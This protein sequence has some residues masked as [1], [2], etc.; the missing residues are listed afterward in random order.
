MPAVYVSCLQFDADSFTQVFCLVL[1]GLGL[2]SANPLALVPSVAA[3]PISDH[4]FAAA[5]RLFCLVQVGLV[6][7]RQRA[8]PRPRFAVACACFAL[9]AIAEAAAG[10]D[11]AQL[12]A[13]AQT[14][15]VVVLPSE[16]LLVAADAVFAAVAVAWAALA[17]WQTQPPR[18]RLLV[19]VAFIAI[20]LAATVFTHVICLMRNL[21]AYTVLPSMIYNIAQMTVGAFVLFLMRPEKSDVYMMIGHDEFEEEE[22]R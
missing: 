15:R 2:L 13:D 8:P 16:E 20:G 3:P 5:L 17:L 6:R 4:A 19:F 12:I 1:G 9:Y 11:R 10:F 18:L 14:E 21:F 22:E 7:A